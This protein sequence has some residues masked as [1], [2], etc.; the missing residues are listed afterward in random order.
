MHARYCSPLLGRFLSVD[1]G[2][3]NSVQPQSW[4]RYTYVRGNPLKYTDPTGQYTVACAEGDE[5]CQNS[6][7]QFEAARQVALQH[8]NEDVRN[9]ALAYGDPGEANGITVAFGNPVRTRLLPS[10]ATSRVMRM[11]RSRLSAP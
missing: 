6:A 4:N 2:L 7:A 9:A 1:P 11:E 5:E 3:G 8:R 10:K